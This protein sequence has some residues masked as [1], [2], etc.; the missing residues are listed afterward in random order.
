MN[1]ATLSTTLGRAAPAASHAAIQLVVHSTSDTKIFVRRA[2][3]VGDEMRVSHHLK[4]NPSATKALAIPRS[5]SD[6]IAIAIDD[7]DRALGMQ[8]YRWSRAEM[9]RAYAIA[10]P[11]RPVPTDAEKIEL[12]NAEVLS[13]ADEDVDLEVERAKWEE[14]QARCAE[15]ATESEG[16]SATEHA[17]LSRCEFEYVADGAQAQRV[18]P[19]ART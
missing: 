7:D 1:H 16:A 17:A 12:W 14:E 8:V 4:V 9:R 13:F 11:H 6:A 5:P 19:A 3:G 15:C 10:H 2:D 18:D